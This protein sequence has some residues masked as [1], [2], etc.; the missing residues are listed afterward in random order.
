[1]SPRGQVDLQPIS[2]QEAVGYPVLDCSHGATVENALVL[3]QDRLFLLVDSNGN[4]SPPGQCGLGLFFDDTRILSHYAL[5]FAGGSPALLSSQVPQ[6][7]N[8]Q[9]DLAIDD[10]EFGGNAW[11]PKNSVHIRREFLLQDQL[12][13]RVTLTNYL[14]APIDFRMELDLGSDF[15]DIFEVRGWR[16]PERGQ[17][18]APQVT[19]R[20]IAF[21]YRGRDGELIWS[22]VDFPQPPDEIRSHGARWA[23]RLEPGKR[24]A[25]EWQIVP[26]PPHALEPAAEGGLLPERRPQVAAL[27][28]EWRS[29]C[30][31]WQTDVAEFN[32]S[33][34]RAIDDM[35]A[36]YITADGEQVISAG[37][38]WYSTAFGR[39]SL[40][41][42]LQMLP[43]NPR[44][45]TDTLRYLAH[46]QGE[47]EDP[48][49]EE[50]PGKIMH[51]L[52]RG[53]MARAGEIPH[54]PYYGTIDGT[55]L[56]LVLLHETWRWTGD[57]DLVRQLLP[58]AERAL[59][60]IDR[61]GDIDGDGLVEYHRT[62][63]KGAGEPG[64][65]RF[66]GWGALPRWHSPGAPDR[67]GRGAGI[68]LRCEGAHGR[69][70]RGAG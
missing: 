54:V 51:E 64:V 30:T 48:F 1:M 18:F 5:R 11:D 67:I 21:A 38:P 65:E 40:I 60:W 19:E 46:H 36:L 55:P 57:A 69:A 56:W 43:V 66:G 25:I 34:R 20:S 9:V 16:R 4:I 6:A 45:A 58:N 17:F 59:E 15:A 27:Y 37:I 29:E 50:Q 63:E 47:K 61:F 68:C 41:T 12:T 42:S 33:L 53:E 26:E 62:S 3:K 70:L 7:Y 8:A 52:R 49:T 22:T 13:E 28:K 10:R 32:A 31:A 23:M 39:D 44:V 24:Y 14:T 35:R 2:M